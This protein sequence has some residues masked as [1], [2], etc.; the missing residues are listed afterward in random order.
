MGKKTEKSNN[1]QT[2]ALGLSRVVLS[3]FELKTTDDLKEILRLN[4]AQ[5]QELEDNNRTI[6]NELYYRQYPELKRH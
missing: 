1:K 6:E 5:I 4:T 2:Q 3:V